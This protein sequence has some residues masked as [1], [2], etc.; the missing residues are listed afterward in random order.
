M[1]G[2]VGSSGVM[3]AHLGAILSSHGA[4]LGSHGGILGPLRANMEAMVRSK[5]GISE[6]WGAP[7]RGRG[8][9]TVLCTLVCMY[10]TVR[11]LHAQRHRAS[12]DTIK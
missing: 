3:L 1:V 5:V 11:D 8:G 6:N 2:Y 9:G 7:G 12:A 4:L 10:C